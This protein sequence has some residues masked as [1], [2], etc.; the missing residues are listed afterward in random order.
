MKQTGFS[1]MEIL[2]VT[3][4]AM[5]VGSILLAILVNQAGVFYQQNAL[6]SQGVSLNDALGVIADDVRQSSKIVISYPE[7]IP[8]YQTSSSTLVLKLFSI[9]NSGT[10]STSAYD[11]I[12]ITPDPNNSRVLRRKVFPS[13]IST[14]KSADQ[15]LTTIL[16]SITFSYLDKN[17]NSV[18][19]SM[20]VDVNT[21]LTVLARTN[22]T[23]AS[24]S[25]STIAGIRNAP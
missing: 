21:S 7:D 20:A 8:Q 16:Q 23:T 6:I 9:D 17:G 13:G 4:V 5:L 25:A 19:P 10:S 12:V 14:R 1:L 3:S 2:I 11:Y 15:V 18:D 24:Q 22:G